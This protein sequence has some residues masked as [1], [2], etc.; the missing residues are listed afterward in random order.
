MGY[1]VGVTPI[2]MAAAVSSIANAG[3]YV[4]PRVVRAAYHD[5]RRFG[6][7]PKTVRRT[8]SA[9]TAAQLTGIMEQVVERGTGTAARIPGYTIAG[10]TGTANTLVNG[11]YTNSTFA[12]FV[13]FL[14]SNDPKLTVLVMLDS[15]RGP[16]GHF[17]GPVS[18]PIFKRIAEAAL[19]YLGVPPSINPA[20]PVLVTRH[21]AG[22]PVETVATEEAPI[23]DVVVEVPPGTAPDVRGLSARDAMRKLV[24]AGLSAQLAGDGYVVSQ[25]PAPGEPIDAG[26][27]CRLTLARAPIRQVASG[28]QP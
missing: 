2:Q 21:E 17:G 7:K 23:A 25:D 27:V 20:P 14:P 22:G 16:N 26:S 4:E 10:K 13:G 15:P 19:R 24:K 6:V 3:E 1:Q 12:S 8:V 28:V 5:E 11:R 18:A 9:E